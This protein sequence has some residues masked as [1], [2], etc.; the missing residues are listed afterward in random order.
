MCMSGQLLL[1]HYC[2]FACIYVTQM[3][4]SYEDWLVCGYAALIVVLCIN[5]DILP[6]EINWQDASITFND[7]RCIVTGLFSSSTS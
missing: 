5:P 4:W 3:N 6:T 2:L 1:A 7:H